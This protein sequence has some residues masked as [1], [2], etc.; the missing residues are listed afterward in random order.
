[1]QS[2]DRRAKTADSRKDETLGVHDVIGSND[3]TN[4]KAELLNRISDESGKAQRLM[5]RPKGIW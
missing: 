2:L 5:N 4:G 3:V 1:V